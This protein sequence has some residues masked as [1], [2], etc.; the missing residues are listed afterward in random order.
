MLAFYPLWRATSPCPSDII[1]RTELAT[2]LGGFEEHFSGMYGMYEDQAF[3]ARVYLAPAVYFASSIWL[4][5]REHPE[6]Y[7]ATVTRAG[8]YDRVRENFLE[9][10]DAYLKIRSGVDPRVQGAL[11]KAVRRYRHPL[12]HALFRIAERVRS[13]LRPLQGSVLRRR[14]RRSL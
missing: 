14:A 10:L 4:K 5:Y 7:V 1:L 13:V 12:I 11:R 2:S 9:W 3:L 6:S 8:G